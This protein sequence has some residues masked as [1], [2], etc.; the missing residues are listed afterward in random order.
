[1]TR[2]TL[3]GLEALSAGLMY[4]LLTGNPVHS[5]PAPRGFLKVPWAEPHTYRPRSLALTSSPILSQMHTIFIRARLPGKLGW[6]RG[7]REGFPEE[8]ALKGKEWR[9][10]WK[11]EQ[12]EPGPGELTVSD[13]WEAGG[14]GRPRGEGRAGTWLALPRGAGRRS[15]SNSPRDRPLLTLLTLCICQPVAHRPHCQS[16]RHG[17]RR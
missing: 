13:F 9:P 15:R 2:R 3:A 7:T 8:Q 11:R 10:E 5:F 17:P 12:L 14:K 1:M 6:P 16:T 4:R